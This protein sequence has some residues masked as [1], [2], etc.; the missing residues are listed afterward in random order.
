MKRSHGKFLIAAVIPVMIAAVPSVSFA[1]CIGGVPQGPAT[2]DPAVRIP[3][4]TAIGAGTDIGPAV[5]IGGYVDIGQCGQ[6]GMDSS[7]V[8]VG[9][10]AQIGDGVSLTN[11]STIGGH[12]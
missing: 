1:T 12:A 3:R 5:S 9:S 11:A 10:R 4:T 8:R 7:A 6:V 2:W